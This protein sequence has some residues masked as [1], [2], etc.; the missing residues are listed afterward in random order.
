MAVTVKGRS[1]IRSNPSANRIVRRIEPWTFEPKENT[2]LHRLERA[3]L[4][5]L[6]AVDAVEARKVKAE[7][8]GTLTPSGIANDVLSFAASKLAPQLQ[9]AKRAVEQAKAEAADRRA[10]LTLKKS[11]PTDA[12][13]Q[14][15]RLW[16]LDRFN[17]MS[18]IERNAYLAKA[19][20]NLDPELQQAF[21]EAPEYSKVLPTD[22]EAIHMRALKQ[23]HG[24]TITEL[25]NLEA[26]IK[27]VDDVITAAR[28]EVAQEVGGTAKLD[29]AAAP[30]EKMQS[31]AWLRKFNENGSDVVKS[32][33]IVGNRGHWDT[34]TEEEVEGG[35]YF[36]SA[37]EWRMAQSGAIPQ[38]M[39]EQGNGQF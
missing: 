36:K 27:I 33:H 2:A 4:D 37:D 14:I 29:A 7:K 10:K 23:Q 8:S 22:L 5:A 25:A 28:D 19:G 16:R 26:G 32:F 38:H 13:G 39:K 1:T 24:E 3:Y 15:R 35:M 17:A 30:Y 9:K 20:D 12:A 21:L 34:A 18:D 11:D 6:E 31:A